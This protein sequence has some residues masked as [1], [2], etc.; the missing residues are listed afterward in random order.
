MS[1]RQVSGLDLPVLWSLASQAHP[2]SH[3]PG[4][5][6]S[7]GVVGGVVIAGGPPWGWRPQVSGAL[8]VILLR[9]DLDWPSSLAAAPLTYTSG[10]NFPLP[11]A[12]G[13]FV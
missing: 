12:A 1:Q 4:R 13:V 2:S 8:E 9:Q 7:D 11:L 6:S 5:R 3:T 10:R